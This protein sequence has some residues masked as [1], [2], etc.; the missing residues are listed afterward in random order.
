MSNKAKGARSSPFSCENRKRKP[1]GNKAKKEYSKSGNPKLTAVGRR[2]QGGH[3]YIC[4][5][6]V[7]LSHN[8]FKETSRRIL[9]RT[10]THKR[11]EEEEE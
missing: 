6:C 8:T 1:R 7:L 3:S 10:I 4:P 5:C 9:R 2:K 11:V